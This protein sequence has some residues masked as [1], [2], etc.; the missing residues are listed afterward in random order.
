MGRDGGR[1]IGPWDLLVDGNHL[2]IGGGFW[3]VAGLERTFLTRFT[4]S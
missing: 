3:E 2:Y 1:A 4:F